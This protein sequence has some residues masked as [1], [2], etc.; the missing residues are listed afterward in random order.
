M[1]SSPT[2]RIRRA[3][4]RIIPQKTARIIQYLRRLNGVDSMVHPPTCSHVRHHVIHTNG[5]GQ[6]RQQWYPVDHVWL[7]P[8]PRLEVLH[9]ARCPRRPHRPPQ[10]LGDMDHAHRPSGARRHGPCVDLHAVFASPVL[11]RVSNM[12]RPWEAQASR[13]DPGRIPHRHLTPEEHHRRGLGGG[14]WVAMLTTRGRLSA[15][16]VCQS[17]RWDLWGLRS[18]SME[19]A[20]KAA[21][22]RGGSATCG[23]YWRRGPRPPYGPAEGHERAA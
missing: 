19:G 20:G 9:A 1:G 5:I 8:E 7:A 2:V 21:A 13:V 6:C 10:G 11:G 18:C 15:H 4:G 12:A 17:A 23:P 22:G 16:G 3:I 14:R